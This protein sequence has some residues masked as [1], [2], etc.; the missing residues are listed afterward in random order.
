M[1]KSK[2][3]YIKTQQYIKRILRKSINRIENKD[4]NSS[5]KLIAQRIEDFRIAA[6]YCKSIPN[7]LYK[8]RS[9]NENNFSA[10]EKKSIWLSSAQEFR[11]PYDCKLALTVKSLSDNRINKLAKWFLFSEYIYG[12]K[13]ENLSNNKYAFTPEEVRNL[14]FSKCYTDELYLNSNEIK[15]YINKNYSS[16]DPHKIETKFC[17]FDKVVSRYGRGEKLREWFRMDSEKGLIDSINKHRKEYCIC[18]LTETNDN[19]KM[20]EEYADEYRGFCIDYDFSFGVT[21]D[22]IN[23]KDCLLALQ[24]LLPVFYSKRRALID[25]YNH[26]MKQYQEVFFETEK[27]YWDP[28]YG[29]ELMMQNLIKSQYYETEQEWRVVLIGD[30]SGLIYFPFA[31]AVYLGKDIKVEDKQRLLDIAKKININVYQQVAEINGYKYVKI[32]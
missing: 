2:K 20:W 9:C 22:L 31:T 8:Y 17:C 16:V 19:A 6:I 14:M 3:S 26:L 25:A 11:D 18:S 15:K 5:E 4:Y 7:H 1:N 23:H 12:Y 28:K 30:E 32:Q 27:D 21:K 24:F 29:S 13:K 10:L